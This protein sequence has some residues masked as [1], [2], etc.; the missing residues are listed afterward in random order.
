MRGCPKSKLVVGIPTYGR[1][2]TLSSSSATSLGSPASGAGAAGPVTG[3]GGFLAYN[4]ICQNVQSGVFTKVT[5]PT[6]KMGPYAHGGRQWVGYDDPA[7]AAVKAQYILDNKLGGGMFWDLPS[8][9]F[10]N[11]FVVV[12]VVEKSMFNHN[13]IGVVAALIPS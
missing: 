1:S 6:H 2:W 7:M 13:L 3:E 11:K 10:R 9:D 8:D 12:V 5:H 4:E